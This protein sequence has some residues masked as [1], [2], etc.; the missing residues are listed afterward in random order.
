MY[1]CGGGG[2]EAAYWDLLDRVI[3]LSVD[4]ETLGH[5]LATRTNNSFGKAPHQREATL[6]AKLTWE[7][8]YRERGAVILDG[9]KPLD[10]V[11]AEVIEAAEA[12]Y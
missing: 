1:L 11:V 6:N 4:N 2:D 8:S 12:P 10:E 7:A 3:L 5:R 9:T